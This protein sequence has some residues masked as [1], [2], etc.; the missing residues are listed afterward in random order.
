MSRIDLPVFVLKQVGHGALQDARLP[1][2]KPR[3]MLATH[4][5]T[6]SG[7]HPYHLDLGITEERMEQS[8]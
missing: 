7:F 3:R 5:P 6:P 1:A 4:N 2:G 8:D